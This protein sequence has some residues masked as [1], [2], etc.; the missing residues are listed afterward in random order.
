MQCTGEYEFCRSLDF[1]RD[2][3]D[4]TLMAV[5]V[6]IFLGGLLFFGWFP[7]YQWVTLFSFIIG[8]TLTV[9]GFAMYFELFKVKLLSKAGVS[10]LLICVLPMLIVTAM[11]CLFIGGKI[12]YRD[13]TTLIP[14]GES[15]LPALGFP[16]TPEVMPSS[17]RQ[18]IRPYGWLTLPISASGLILIIIGSLL[19][20]YDEMF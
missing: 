6:S 14:P 17:M 8:V 16:E 2:N 7:I 10:N 18:V 13:P 12:I 1:S 15:P 20:L 19:K 9:T 3:L 5:A 11:T 4:K